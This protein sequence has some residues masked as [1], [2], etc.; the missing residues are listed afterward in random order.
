VITERRENGR[1]TLLGRKRTKKRKKMVE[2][3]KGEKNIKIAL[4]SDKWGGGGRGGK[5]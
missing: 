2:R 4:G 5:R 3:N 1:N